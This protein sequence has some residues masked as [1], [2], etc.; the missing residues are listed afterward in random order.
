[1]PPIIVPAGTV[2]GR[3]AVIKEVEPKSSSSGIIR[4]FECRCLCGNQNKVALNSLRSGGSQS[5]GCVYTKHGKSRTAEH[6]IWIHM[7]ERCL[8]PNSGSFKHYGG[9]GIRVCER[10][11]SFSNFLGDMGARPSA[12]HSIERINNNGNYEP[13]NC[14][15][16]TVYEQA[17]NRSNT[18]ILILNGVARCLSE[19]AS[20]TG[21]NVQTIHERLKRGK[22][23]EQ[24]LCLY[25][26]IHITRSQ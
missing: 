11:D 21:L 15:W 13:E 16:A 22:S 25:K 20:I 26:Q 12:R 3:W 7:R 8:N 19:W 4:F 1:M 17:R 5:C 6:K 10:W 23:D 24:A 9:R 2:F 18:R 14:K